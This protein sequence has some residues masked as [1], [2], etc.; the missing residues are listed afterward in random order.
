MF[1]AVFVGLL[2]AVAAGAFDGHSIDQRL[3]VASHRAVL[4][5]GALLTAARDVTALGSPQVV[6]ILTA[7][8]A[9]VL[10]VIGRRR[11]AVVI[12]AVRV[13][14]WLVSTAT[15]VAVDRPR[16]HFSVA[17][18]H[19]SGGSFPSGH[20]SGAA[21][22]YLPMA[23]LGTALFTTRAMRGFALG[24]A[25]LGL[26]W[27]TAQQGARLPTSTPEGPAPTLTKR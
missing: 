13:I 6:D 12:L 10:F 21:S 26:C 2:A 15:K 24:A 3:A 11:H 27:A 14:T 5:H 22:F 9:V 8:A 4:H 7:I 23:L 16:P 18:G 20:E 17:V 19:W 25:V 1:A